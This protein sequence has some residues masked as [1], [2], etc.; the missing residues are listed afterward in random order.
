MYCGEAIPVQHRLSNEQVQS[1][2]S[3]KH[4]KWKE[5]QKKSN[6]WGSFPKPKRSNVSWSI[7]TDWFSVGG[8]IDDD[9]WDDDA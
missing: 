3:S 9:G 8:E 5:E 1:L 2:L 6:Q 7:Q 4:E